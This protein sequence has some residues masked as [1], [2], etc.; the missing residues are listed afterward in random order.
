MKNKMLE[1]L[2][3]FANECSTSDYG[4]FE[5]CKGEYIDCE[6]YKKIIAQ[7]IEDY[8]EKRK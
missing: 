2:C 3:T 1:E 6:F 7:K 8:N 5:I 4:N